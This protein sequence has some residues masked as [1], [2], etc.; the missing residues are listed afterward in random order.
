MSLAKILGPLLLL[1][2]TAGGQQPTCLAYEADTVSPSGRLG[3]RVYPGRP[4]YESLRAGD[5]PDTVFAEG[6]LPASALNSGLPIWGHARRIGSLL[7]VGAIASAG[8]AY[9]DSRISHKARSASR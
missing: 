1:T 3:R 9:I 2:A 7:A 4:N 8:I 6:R 5:Q